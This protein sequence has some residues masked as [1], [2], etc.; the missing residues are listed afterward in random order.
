MSTTVI[1]DAWLEKAAD[2]LQSDTFDF[3]VSFFRIGEGGWITSSGTKVSRAADPTLT[4][5][6]CIQNP[7]RYTV[8]SRWSFQKSITSA[9]ITEVTSKSVKVQCLVDTSE[10]N[11]DSSGFPPEFWEL[12]IFDGDGTMI[13]YTTFSRQPKDDSVALRHYITIALVRA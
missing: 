11:L 8:D 9:M 7:S 2:G 3:G 10:A 1:T 13:S 12:G 4:N 6:D 5:I